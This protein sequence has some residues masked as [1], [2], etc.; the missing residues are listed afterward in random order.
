VTS[1]HAFAGF[2]PSVEGLPAPDTREARTPLR[3]ADAQRP[4]RASAPTSLLPIPRPPA[5]DAHLA[6]APGADGRLA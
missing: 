1:L 2:V 4:L 6:V 3:T 5:D